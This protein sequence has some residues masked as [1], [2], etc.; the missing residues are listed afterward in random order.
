MQ[1]VNGVTLGLR[2]PA[3]GTDRG[4][5]TPPSFWGTWTSREFHIWTW[6]DCVG[7][8]ASLGEVRTAS[9]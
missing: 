1:T 8:A 5:P 7:L 4:L 6:S 2:E 9:Y 3:C